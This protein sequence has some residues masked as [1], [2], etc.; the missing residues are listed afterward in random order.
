MYNKNMHN[1]DPSN[2]CEEKRE[3]ET[4]FEGD[5]PYTTQ[6]TYDKEH[7]TTNKVYNSIPLYIQKLI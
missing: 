5:T 4:Y 3:Y 6:R 7:P 1:T 2:L